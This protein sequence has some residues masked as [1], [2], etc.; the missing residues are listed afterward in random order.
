ML[1]FRRGV[2]QVVPIVGHLI[3]DAWRFLRTAVRS[4]A[5]L[6][7]EILF[8]RKQLAFYQER[9]IKPRRLTDPARAALLVFS[10]LFNW[11]DALV[12]VRPE[13]LIR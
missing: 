7:A 11:R 4:R 1:V 8:L 9:E 13:T 12:I 10:R 5:A 6:S 3:L 2:L